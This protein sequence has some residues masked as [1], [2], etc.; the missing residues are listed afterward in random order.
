[1]KLTQKF[2]II[3]VLTIKSTRTHVEKPRLFDEKDLRKTVKTKDI[4]GVNINNTAA[5]S[6]FA[7]YPKGAAPKPK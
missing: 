7:A 6:G 4:I 3:K 1:M 2:K 5:F